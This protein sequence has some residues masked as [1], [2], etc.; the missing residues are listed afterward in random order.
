M[1]QLETPR[2]TKSEQTSFSPFIRLV[3]DVTDLQVERPVLRLQRAAGGSLCRQQ[4][5]RKQKSTHHYW[6]TQTQSQPQLFSLK[7]VCV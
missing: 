7:Y 6:K 2:V 3:D 4:R 5:R 1:C